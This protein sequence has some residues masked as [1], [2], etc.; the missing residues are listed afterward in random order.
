MLCSDD[1][2]LAELLLQDD[3]RRGYAIDESSNLGTSFIRVA[4]IG[5]SRRMLEADI[6]QRSWVIEV[7]FLFSSKCRFCDHLMV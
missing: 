5:F 6:A 4:L 3:W 2:V 1:V 7:E